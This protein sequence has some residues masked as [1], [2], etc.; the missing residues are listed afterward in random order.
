MNKLFKIIKKILKSRKGKKYYKSELQRVER[1]RDMLCEDVLYQQAKNKDLK[2]DYESIEKINRIFERELASSNK[3][4]EKLAKENISLQQL[5][6]NR[7]R[8]IEDLKTKIAYME[9]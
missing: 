3:E 7:I 5:S 1:Q 6:D 9:E 2:Q 8:K 4:K